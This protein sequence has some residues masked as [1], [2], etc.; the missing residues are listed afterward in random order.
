[1]NNHAFPHSTTNLPPPSLDIM[2]QKKWT[3]C[4]NFTATGNG[5]STSQTLVL[6]RAFQSLRRVKSFHS[7]QNKTLQHVM[8]GQWPPNYIQKS[9]DIKRHPWL[10][11]HMIIMCKNID[12]GK[13]MEFM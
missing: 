10:K 4:G 12:L 7:S 2:I 13:Q 1:M 11:S 5:T 9:K 3:E 8:T 6:S